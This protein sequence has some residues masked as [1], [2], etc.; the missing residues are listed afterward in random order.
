MN[1]SNE[2]TYLD[3][4][5]FPYPFCPGCGHGTI[6][7]QLNLALT[8]LN[9][10]PHKVVLV[11]DIGCQGLSDQFFTTNSF[12]GLHGRSVTYATGIKLINPE[13]KVIV[14]IGDGGCGIGG[15]HL[16]NAA[17]RNIGVTVLV[18]N[19][20]NYGMTGGEHS[21]T[22]PTG[23]FTS[24]SLM[25]NLEKPMDI[26]ATVGVNGASFV[27]RT[28]SFDKDLSGLIAQAIETEGFSLIDIWE[29]CTAYYVQNNKFNRK[30]LEDTIASNNFSTGILHRE[31]RTEYSKA[32]RNIRQDQLNKSTF[33]SIQIENR[34]SHQLKS[35]QTLIIS[36]TAGKRI[37]TTATIFCRAALLS[38]LF[39]TQRDDYPVTVKTGFSFAE[40]TLSP[41][42]TRITGNS[43]PDV[44]IVLSQEGFKK[45]QPKFE[46]LTEQGTI[47]LEKNLPEIKSKA[48][49]IRL[50]FEKTGLK[51]EYWAL[52]CLAYLLR[53]TG[54]FPMNA[55]TDAVSMRK[56]F[57]DD[58]LN[59][60]NGSQ[61]L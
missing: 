12:H 41:D 22:T 11:T 37:G 40:V 48:K 34:Y 9:L 16:I 53:E 35:L 52:A 47:Y 4:E 43:S 20:L 6:L 24:S 51:K 18:L 27:A 44:V 3:K 33:K 32:Y 2:I 8:K 56:D 45:V 13:L 23:A 57:A 58:Y 21:A 36:G 15:H 60:I 29:L 61:N 25:G 17:R 7:D 55:L 28:T 30:A 54:I 50:D 49:Q 5:K 38:G 59:A 14:L 19:N 39:A 10:D 31:D 46:S 1:N 26:C 42:N